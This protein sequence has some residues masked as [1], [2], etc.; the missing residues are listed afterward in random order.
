[1]SDTRIDDGGPAF[2]TKVGRSNLPLQ[3]GNDEFIMPGMTLRDYFAIHGPAP[4]A[5]AIKHHG[6]VERMA[7]PHN[8]PYGKPV[9]HSAD[10]IAVILRYQFASR[11][12][13]EREKDL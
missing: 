2:P 12:L 4:T 13:A 8:E 10:E 11:M 5:E 7:N 3:V 6:E 1:M 9:R